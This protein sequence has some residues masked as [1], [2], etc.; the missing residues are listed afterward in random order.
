M[1]QRYRNKRRQSEPTDTADKGKQKKI[2]TISHAV[3]LE[4]D[5]EECDSDVVVYER[6]MK[7]LLSEYQKQPTKDSHFQKLTH[8]IWRE[9]INTSA[10]AAVDI[11]EEYPKSKL[12]CVLTVNYV[13]YC[14]CHNS[15]MCSW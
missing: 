5:D 9:K 11:Q 1:S 12:T 7:V 10:A 14:L 4:V 13:H 15:G 3:P 2:I 6:N 8:K